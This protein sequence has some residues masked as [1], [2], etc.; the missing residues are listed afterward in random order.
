MQ[1]CSSEVKLILLVLLCLP[2]CTPTETNTLVSERYEFNQSYFTQG[3]TQYN[4]TAMIQ[5]NGLYGE[6][7]IRIIDVYTQEVYKEKMLP[8]TVF[9]EGNTYIN[10]TIILLTWHNEEA[11]Y[12]DTGLEILEKKTYR[13]EGWGLTHNNTHLVMSNG[14]TKLQLR[15][16]DTFHLQKTVN[17]TKNDA[18]VT[19]LNELTYRE[20]YIYANVWL[21]DKIVKIDLSTGNVTETYTFPKKN[22]L[23]L[24]EREQADVLNGVMNWNNTIYITGKHYPY[25][26]QTKI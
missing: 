3:L 22:L 16:P 7:A 9:A 8:P 14:S 1:T 4:E 26:Y 17:V 12:L 21:T 15:D 25:I 6:S 5:S 2:A 24:A 19:N 10:N 23:T 18:P 13:G 11:Y 20:G